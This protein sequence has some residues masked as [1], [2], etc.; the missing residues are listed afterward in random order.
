M[1]AS[2][3]LLEMTKRTRPETSATTSRPG[4]SKFATIRVPLAVLVLAVVLASVA[5][6]SRSGAS[7][8]KSSASG[9]AQSSPS[10]KASKVPFPDEARRIPGDPY[11]Q[12]RIDAPVVMVMWSEFQCPFCGRFARNTEPALIKQFVDTGI[13][14]I[15][16]HDFPYLGPDSTTAAIAGRA[17]AAQNKFWAFH[18]AVYATQHRVN[19]GDLDAGHLRNYAVKAGLDMVRY[20]ADM[21]AK[22][23]A[24]QVQADL[25]EGIALGITGTPAFL[26]NGNPILGAQPT[27]VFISM[28][29]QAKASAKARP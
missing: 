3:T 28:I 10:T 2:T 11:A 17:A 1:E 24:A 8:G 19:Q 5:L 29:E 9:Q 14:R 25:S 22:M 23:S 4:R 18:D 12:G 20:D 15:E 27:S 13:L 21:K 6:I 26:I 7:S 16:W